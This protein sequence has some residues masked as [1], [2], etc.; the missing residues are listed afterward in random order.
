MEKD[1]SS[2]GIFEWYVKCHYNS[3]AAARMSNRERLTA[4][5]MASPQYYNLK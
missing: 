4:N 2:I 3:H 1:Y 5:S